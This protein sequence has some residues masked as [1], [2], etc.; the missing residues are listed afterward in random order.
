MAT[1]YTIFKT[2]ED[3]PSGETIVA[4]GQAEAS[5][6]E[7]ALRQFLNLDGNEDLAK[8]GA[9]FHVIPKANIHTLTPKIETR[10]Q[11]SFT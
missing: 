7:S 2:V 4:L 10:T 6:P 11:L 5:S 3:D 1:T 8:S 9:E